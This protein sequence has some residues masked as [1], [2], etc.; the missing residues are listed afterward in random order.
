MNYY[1]AYLQCIR[2]QLPLL[3]CVEDVLNEMSSMVLLHDLYGMRKVTTSQPYDGCI[4]LHQN[5]IDYCVC[6]DDFNSSFKSVAVTDASISV[7]KLMRGCVIENISTFKR[8]ESHEYKQ[9]LLELQRLEKVIQGECILP[10]WEWRN[11]NEVS[12]EG[13][14]FLSHPEPEL[15][16]LHGDYLNQPEMRYLSIYKRIKP[17]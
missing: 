11:I 8:V 15:I 7:L 4:D 12:L 14:R 5:W 13:K 2:E 16:P 10:E 17:D 9:A 1:C 3:S 6:S